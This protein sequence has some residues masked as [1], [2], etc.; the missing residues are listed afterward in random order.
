MGPADL[1]EILAG[2]GTAES[3][4][5]IV[6]PGDDAG[7][8]LIGD[9]AVVETVDVITPV[10]NDPA[11]FGAIGAANSLSDVY[12]MGGTP[13]AALAVAGFPSCDYEPI[14]LREIL[15]GAVGVLKR[16][17][18]ALLGGH[19][20]DD[21]EIKFGLSVTGVVD[22]QRILKVSG[23]REGDVIAI[24]KPLGIGILTTALKG[25]KLTDEEI[26][27]AVEWML[28][29]NDRASAAALAAGATAC[30][31][32]TG[33]GLLGHA[34]NMVGG[35]SV[36]FILE[37]RSIPVLERVSAMMERGMVPEGAYNNL[38]FVDGKVD[39]SSGLSDE[40][41]LLLADPQ[42]SGGLLV[43]LP[44]E[45]VQRF[46]EASLFFALIGRVVKGAGSIIVQ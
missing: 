7:I 6:G 28:T 32:V 4:A 22:R 21:G 1:E 41:K 45:G 31:D 8:H 44:E 25:G 35:S 12:A 18:T 26:R 11:V 23:A 10:V 20:F 19:T 24:T 17:G 42:T 13:R 30:T 37:R 3:A 36:D 34:A 39:F 5:V 9:M 16:A 27:P 38:T 40:D 14:V 29:L 43:T 33:F 46:E 15:R 2:I